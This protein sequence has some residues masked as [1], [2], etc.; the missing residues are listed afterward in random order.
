[1]G[2]VPMVEL[3]IK[4]RSPVSPSDNEGQTPLHHA[5]AEG[6]GKYLLFSPFVLCL[7]GKED[8]ADEKE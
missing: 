8:E 4:N 6:H 5:V 3:L 7:G 1:M 2:S